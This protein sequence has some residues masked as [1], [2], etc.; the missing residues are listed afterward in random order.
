LTVDAKTNTCSCHRKEFTDNSG[1]AGS[2]INMEVIESTLIAV[3]QKMISICDTHRNDNSQA[4]ER[5]NSTAQ[6][7]RGVQR[8]IKTATDKKS[9]L[10]DQYCYGD[11]TRSAYIQLRDAEDET[12]AKL[13]NELLDLVCYQNEL[14]ADPYEEVKK[15]LDGVTWNG[16]LTREITE[17]LLERVVAYDDGR[18]EIQWLFSDPFAMESK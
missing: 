2:A 10:Y 16:V 1:C 14:Y 15:R 11:L 9:A 18:F 13:N 7:I 12:I 17:A 4:S 6:S 5:P 8:Q 3:I